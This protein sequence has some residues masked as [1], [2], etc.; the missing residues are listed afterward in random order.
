MTKIQIYARNVRNARNFLSICNCH[1]A[2][3]FK[4]LYPNTYV[5]EGAFEIMIGE[6]NYAHEAYGDKRFDINAE[7][8]KD[9]S[10]H[11]DDVIDEIEVFDEL[12]VTF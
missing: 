2:N 10:I 5:A 6:T 11:D 4:E 8:C 9:Q 7:K 3:R 1:L 12:P